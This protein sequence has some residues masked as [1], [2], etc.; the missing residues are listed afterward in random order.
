MA[1]HKVFK[2]MLK[3]NLTKSK[4]LKWEN[5]DLNPNKYGDGDGD[6]LRALSALK[7]IGLSPKPKFNLHAQ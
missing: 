1:I 3:L 6:Y 5:V 4:T 7:L 2:D